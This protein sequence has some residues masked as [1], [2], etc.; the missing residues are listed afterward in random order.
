[1]FNPLFIEIFFLGV[2]NL[3][4]STKIKLIYTFLDSAVQ[5]CSHLN[6]V[7]KSH[8]YSVIALGLICL[9]TSDDLRNQCMEEG[10]EKVQN[11][12]RN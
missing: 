3:T 12:Q 4:D 9:V 10:K 6:A 5:T 8:M 1:M 2:L 11:T 7:A